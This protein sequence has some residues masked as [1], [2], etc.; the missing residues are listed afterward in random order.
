IAGSAPLTFQWY[1][2]GSAVRNNAGISGATSTALTIASVTNSDAG[3]YSVVASNYFHSFVL[4]SNAVLAVNDPIFTYSPQSLTVSYQQGATL[5]S[6]ASGTAP[7]SYQWQFNGA[8]LTDNGNVSGSQSPTLV[9]RGLTYANNGTYTAMATNGLTNTATSP[10]A[11]LSVI[12]PK[13]I[14]LP[15]NQT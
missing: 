8:N 2:N 10:P 11:I 15:V 3:T 1:K 13:L 6:S 9:L 7:L 5:F 14:S 4:S 12:D